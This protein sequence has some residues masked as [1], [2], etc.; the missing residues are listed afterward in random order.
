MAEIA[1]EPTPN[2]IKR[3]GASRRIDVTCNAT[4]RDLGSVAREIERKVREVKFPLGTHPELLGEFAAREEAGKRLLLLGVVAVL[5]IIALLQADFQNGR[6]TMI[7][8]LSLPFALV[9]GV[10]A[11]LFTDRV[12]SIGSLVGFVTVIGIAARNGIMLVSH[13]RHMHLTEGVPVGPG[14]FLRGAQERLAPILMTAS[15]A[16]LALVP[17]VWKGN[18]PGQEIEFPMA[19]VILG[20]LATSTLLNL[21]L[22]PALVAKWGGLE[23]QQ[24]DRA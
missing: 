7:V 15:C 2:E 14:L 9:G 8:A 18:V 6:L 5:G 1:F 24:D 22:L 16:G 13:Y 21:L 17:L 12:L 4:G 10:F 11:S 19:V 23:H 20:G 3:E